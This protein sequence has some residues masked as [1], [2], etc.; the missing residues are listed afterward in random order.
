MR[1]RALL[2]LVF[3]A[4]FVPVFADDLPYSRQEDIIYRRKYG[5]ALT[6]DVFRPKQNANGLGIIFV[7]SGGWYSSHDAG[8][9][10]VS[11]F[12][13]LLQRGY[14]VFA[15]VHGSQ[16]KF[17][18]PEVVEDMRRS[19]RFIR[20][21]AADY[22]VDPN[23]LGVTG[24]SAGG[25]LS[26]MLGTT[27]DD[28][29]PKAKDPV[30]RVS[31]RVQAV[32]CFFPPTDFLNYGQ[33]GENAIGRGTLAAY[34]GAFDFRE[35]EKKG[36]SLAPITDENRILEIGRQ[37]SPITH[38]TAASA[39]TLIVHGDKDKLVPMQ[40][41]ETFLEKLK[42]AG[43]DGKLV[44]KPGAAHGWADMNAELIQLAD[45]FDAHLKKKAEA[46]AK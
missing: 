11:R 40:Q 6:M 46:T 39:P 42:T 4:L 35:L 26:L 44:V 32:A 16:P 23:Q 25:H 21:H 3:T 27:G 45:W 20:F 1:F 31:S 18:I 30:D 19:V 8:G 34:A 38:I 2:V 22:G 10:I 13:I 14:T 9:G 12:S 43:V 28:G 7:V 24:A 17:A 41:A 15:V 33:P 29:D 5:T 36:N 37:I